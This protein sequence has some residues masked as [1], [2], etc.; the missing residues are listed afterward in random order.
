M[1]RASSRC[2]PQRRSS[3]AY[4]EQ[5]LQASDS[6][7]RGVFGRGYTTEYRLL[8]TLNG[9]SGFSGETPNGQAALPYLCEEKS[10]M[11]ARAYAF[12]AL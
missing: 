10:L 6:A 4:L 9:G 8:K 11:H 7:G 12:A 1:G 3:Y 5:F 2:R